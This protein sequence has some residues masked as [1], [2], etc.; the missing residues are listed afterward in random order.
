MPSET[1]LDIVASI[2][3]FIGDILRAQR[4]FWFYPENHPSFAKVLDT[5]F[6]HFRNLNQVGSVVFSV[7]REML[8]VGAIPLDFKKKNN[9]D[10]CTFYIT[11][12]PDSYPEFGG[13]SPELLYFI[14]ILSMDSRMVKHQGGAAKMLSNA[15]INNIKVTEYV[16]D[17]AEFEAS[18]EQGG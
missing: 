5:L 17:T 3:E 6:L 2:H 16:Y 18:R 1:P 14:H 15:G 7:S 12:N 9:R 10:F 4:F 11:P 8:S 13:H